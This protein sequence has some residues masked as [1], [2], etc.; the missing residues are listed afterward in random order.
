MTR[1]NYGKLVL[2]MMIVAMAIAGCG[3]QEVVK[4]SERLQGTWKGTE[5]GGRCGEWKIV[6]TDDKVQ[7]DGPG[8]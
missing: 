2:I 4:D 1:V 5:L 7:A 8:P 3:N 6:I